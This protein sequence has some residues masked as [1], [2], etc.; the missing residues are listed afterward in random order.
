MNPFP[1]GFLLSNI[2]HIIIT[3]PFYFRMNVLLG[4]NTIKLIK[5]LFY[6]MRARATNYTSTLL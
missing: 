2:V 3:L 1:I 4:R 5:N 6:L